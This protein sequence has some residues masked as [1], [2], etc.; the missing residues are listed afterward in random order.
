MVIPFY[1]LYALHGEI[2]TLDIDFNLCNNVNTGLW[3][4]NGHKVAKKANVRQTPNL[5]KI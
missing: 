1:I 5:T 2:L 3:K 4:A